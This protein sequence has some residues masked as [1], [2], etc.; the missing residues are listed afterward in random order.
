MVITAHRNRKTNLKKKNVSFISKIN[1]KLNG[2]SVKQILSLMF[3]AYQQ[4]KIFISLQEFIS[5][6]S[7][8]TS[9]KSDT[10]K[11][12]KT[13]ELSE[14][15]IQKENSKSGQP[16][17]AMKFTVTVTSAT[18]FIKHSSFSAQNCRRTA[19]GYSSGFTVSQIRKHLLENVEGLKEPRISLLTTRRLFQAPNKSLRAAR[20][21][22]GLTDARVEP[23]CNSHRK[24]H[25][26][27]HYLFVRDKHHHEF[28]SRSEKE[29][30][31]PSMDN[32]SKIKAGAPVVSK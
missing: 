32:M 7:K 2:N 15:N 6:Q 16:S 25:I 28:C 10:R 11:C 22:R 5:K 19:M 3:V 30:C 1:V 17:I 23:K 8:T 18:D 27:S 20:L 12:N 9:S 14:N 31:K 21:Y 29:A 4:F 26:D 13:I 24:Y